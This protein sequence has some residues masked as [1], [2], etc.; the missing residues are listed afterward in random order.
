MNSLTVEPLERFQHRPVVLATFTLAQFF[1]N[2]AVSSFAA[3]NR[4]ASRDAAA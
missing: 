4:A 3:S 1:R 2:R